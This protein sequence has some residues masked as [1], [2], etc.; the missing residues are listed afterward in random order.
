[1][2][3]NQYITQYITINNSKL[4]TEILKYQTSPY[5]FATRHQSSSYLLQVLTKDI[6][7]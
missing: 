5:I 4:S 2:Q 6:P 1:M 3:R 7:L